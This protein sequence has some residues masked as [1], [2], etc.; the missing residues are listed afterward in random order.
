MGDDEAAR[1]RRSLRHRVSGRPVHDPPQDGVGSLLVSG[2][3]AGAV[4]K[5]ITA[6][7]D[8]V[9]I[10]YQVSPSRR[11]S[12][13]AVM[14]TG[15]DIVRKSGVTAL[16]RGNSMAVLRDV[17][18]A[19][20]LFSTFSLYEEA[21]CGSLG[22]PTDVLIRGAS[23]CA[24]GATATCLTYPL[25][26][27]RARSALDSSRTCPTHS[28]PCACELTELSRVPGSQL[29]GRPSRGTRA[30][31]KACVRSRRLRGLLL[32]FPVSVPHC[33]ASCPTL[34]FHSPH[35][36]RSSAQL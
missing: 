3:A 5:L 2:G 32:S 4:S 9:K 30:T 6:P 10:M 26:V 36:R 1:C 31:C 14:Q 17:P 15:L 7:I 34:H 13:A 11:F 18:Y 28:P 19:A 8:R 35:S 23:G 25:D 12:L 16:W 22:R 27:L 29:S 33:S 21:L 20:I 24:A